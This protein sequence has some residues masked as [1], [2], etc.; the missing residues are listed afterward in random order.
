MAWLWCCFWYT[1]LFN[2]DSGKNANNL[3]IL[4]ADLS[5]SNDEETKKIIY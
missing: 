2:K 1:T 3:I 4:V 5:D